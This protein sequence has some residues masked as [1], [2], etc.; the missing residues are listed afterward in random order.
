MSHT[1]NPCAQKS[2]F[3]AGEGDRWFERNA[4]A[5]PAGKA[6][7]VL[8]SIRSVGF[9]PAGRAL[10]IGCANGHRLEAI[11]EELGA[12]CY[13]IDPSGK[14]IRS[15]QEDFSDL[16]LRV[17]T[18]DSLPYEDGS[19]DLVILGYCFYLID[20]RLH[21]K[22][23]YEADRVLRDG[24]R[25]VIFDF[26]SPIPYRNQYIHAEGLHSYKMEFRRYFTAHPGYH[27]VHRQLEKKSDKFLE[28][29]YRAGADVLVKVIRRAFPDN[30][31][32]SPAVDSI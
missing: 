22:C 23:G 31:F 1:G 4:G 9:P 14:A 17:G 30:P 28:P 13:G 10:E 11:R 19:F 12:E 27:L 15:G 29:D 21:F 18:A 8:E 26:I 3:L 16:H 24:G 25:L 6:D 7:V 5:L 2:A 20:P 32:Q